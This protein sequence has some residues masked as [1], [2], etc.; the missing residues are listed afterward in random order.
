MANVCF[1]TLRSANRG[2]V[3]LVNFCGPGITQIDKETNFKS[4]SLNKDL[5]YPVSDS[6]ILTE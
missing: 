6:S 1:F 3:S 4:P 5:N 2:F